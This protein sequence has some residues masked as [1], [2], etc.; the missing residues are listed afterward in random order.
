MVVV[1]SKKGRSGQSHAITVD[2]PI[3]IER[4]YCFSEDI[5]SYICSGTPVDCIKIALNDIV[6]QKPDLC[7][8]GINHGSNAAINTMYSGTV[9][10]AMEGAI[11]KYS[12][13]WI[14][15]F[16]R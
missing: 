2:E 3:F 10:A 5:E 15:Y 11:K 7:I 16:R 13:H 1:A 8:C 12:F 4:T 9:S 6:R 14:F